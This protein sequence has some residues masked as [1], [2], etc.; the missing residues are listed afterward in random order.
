MYNDN[1]WR[2]WLLR[3]LATLVLLV[4]TR[5]AVAADGF[6]VD[7][8]IKRDAMVE[9]VVADLPLQQ[10]APLRTAPSNVRSEEASS[11][12]CDG[13]VHV[14]QHGIPGSETICVEPGT[15]TFIVEGIF[16]NVNRQTQWFKDGLHQ[17]TDPTCPF[18]FWADPQFSV[19]I[20]AE[21]TI[22][23]DVYFASAILCT[24]QDLEEVHTWNVTIA[25]PAIHRLAIT[26]IVPTTSAKSIRSAVTF[27][28][29]R[30]AQ[31]QPVLPLLAHVH[32]VVSSGYSGRRIRTADGTCSPVPPRMR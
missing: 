5:V 9:A 29:M 4:T 6:E 1:T 28:G 23:A 2:T 10:R 14:R 32:V 3:S 22:R 27:S 20:D 16:F 12:G 24:I 7:S 8:S 17:E 18:N 26:R 30:C 11:A 31:P 15:H 13:F 25:L 21:T 19:A